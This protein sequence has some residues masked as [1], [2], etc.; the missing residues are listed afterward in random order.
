MSARPQVGSSRS[1]SC[2]GGSRIAPGWPGWSS[3]T[4][5]PT[6]ALDRIFDLFVQGE[7]GIDRAAGGL[8]VGLS[9]ARSVVEAHGGTIA[10]RS[11]GVGT[12]AEFVLTL[13]V[14]DAAMAAASGV[15][16]PVRRRVVLVEDQEDSREVIRMVLELAGHE[17]LTAATGDEG[18]RLIAAHR[19]QIALVDLGLPVLDGF[20]VARRAR[21][22]GINETMLI[23][24]TGYGQPG[25]VERARQA[26][27]DRHLTKPVAT[28]TL[29]DLV[30]AD[31]SPR[32]TSSRT[33]PG[34]GSSD[35]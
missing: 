17:V 26:G 25:D 11:D 8:G 31:P 32:G 23:A 15:A 1:S 20:E 30:S 29:E 4:C 3:S 7:Q 14:D 21:A 18:L 28:G 6:G 22:S 19:P 9:V 2:F 5:R 34:T 12:G 33:G 24:L 27:F 13:P 10:A 16:G 35:R